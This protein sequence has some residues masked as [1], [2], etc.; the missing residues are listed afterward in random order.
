MIR[1]AFVEPNREEWRAWVTECE[2]ERDEL[3]ERRARGEDPEISDLYK[4]KRMKQVYLNDGPP[5]YGKCAYCESRIVGNQ[6]GD[7][8]H[9]RPKNRVTYESGE[10]VMVTDA[11]GAVVKHPG[12]YWLAY[13]WRNLLY[14]CA[15]C[16]RVSSFKTGGV[17]VGKWDKFPVEGEHASAPEDELNERPLLLNP[18]ID[19][20]GEDLSIDETGI[21]AGRTEKG[22]TSIRILGLNLR[23]SLIKD[24]ADAIEQTTNEAIRRTNKFI[25]I[26]DSSN[27]DLHWVYARECVRPVQRPSPDVHPPGQCRGDVYLLR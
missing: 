14:A 15:D 3:V 21:M 8:E 27:N 4:D 6:P 13:D 12:Y 26:F 25:V 18:L 24:R 7:I 11:T 9:F 10:V 19:D 22:K 20:P 17:Q 23:E 1:L 2:R 5:F 16:N